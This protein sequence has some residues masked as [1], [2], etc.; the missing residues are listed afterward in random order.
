MASSVWPASLPQIPLRNG[1]SESGQG[2]TIRTQM[3]VGPA[4]LRAR[5]TAEIVNF[6]ISLVLTTPQRSTLETFYQT[7]T[8]FGSC[9]F[10]WDDFVNGGTAEY[11]FITRPTY[12][13]LA[14]E[15]W[16]T[17]F[18]MERLP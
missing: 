7:T 12:R 1:F 6:N 13:N 4:K 15:L 11:R 18:S 17:T 5:Y 14:D 9:P 16:S 2:A 8:V 3:D 10:D